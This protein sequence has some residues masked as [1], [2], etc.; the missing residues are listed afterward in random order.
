MNQHLEKAR[1]YLEQ[2]E[3]Y[4]HKAAEEIIAA[5]AEDPTLSDRAISEALG[6]S[7][8]WITEIVTWHTNGPN[9]DM[10]TPFAGQYEKVRA[11]LA[12]AAA[13]KDPT[14]IVDA[15]T[16][17][18]PEARREIMRGIAQ[19]PAL[20][21]EMEREQIE[22]TG[23][24]A[25]RENEREWRRQSADGWVALARPLIRAEAALKDA[26]EI[27]RDVTVDDDTARGVLLERI[28]RGKL[29]YE[30]LESHVDGGAA[31]D[32]ALEALLAEADD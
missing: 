12:T 29:L 20:N 9:T 23:R 8:H 30:W 16:K 11:S 25:A 28:E 24:P 7:R 22:H 21:A 6:R 4:Y 10:P 26:V 17:A 18:P 15:I 3:S 19:E 1:T 13:K 27:A 5:R 2:G 14:S 31:F 32:E